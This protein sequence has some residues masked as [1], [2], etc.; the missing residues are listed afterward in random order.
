MCR[1]GLKRWCGFTAKFTL[2]PDVID[3]IEKELN[4][5]GN[6]SVIIRIEGGRLTV[7]TVKPKIIVKK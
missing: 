4:D 7:F 6:Q 2:T 1:N 5:R 3:A